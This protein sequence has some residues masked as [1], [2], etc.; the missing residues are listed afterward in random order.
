MDARGAPARGARRQGRRDRPLQAG[1]RGDAQGRRHPR[2]RCVAPTR[3]AASRRGRRAA[4]ARA[5]RHRGQPRQGAPAR[6]ARGRVPRGSCTTTTAP[7][8]PPRRRTRSTR[9]TSTRS[10]VLGDIAFEGAALRR[11]RASTSSRCS[12]APSCST[13]PTP[14]ACCRGFIEAVG[15][16]C[17]RRVSTPPARHDPSA[18]ALRRGVHPRM[19][20]A[21]DELRSSR[22]TTSTC[23][24]ASRACSFEF[25]DPKMAEAAY[26]RAA[27]R[28][29]R[30]PSSRRARQAALSSRRER[31]TRRE[32]SRPPS[33]TC[34]DAADL[35]P[36]SPLALD[37][38]AKVYEK[39]GQVG[40]VVRVKR[41]RL[42]LAMPS[43]RFDL[44]LEIGDIEFQ[45]LERPAR[46]RRRRSRRR[47]RSGRT[48][49]SS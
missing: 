1:A 39:E 40:G 9:R 15:K 16:R 33:P 5:R 19:I 26:A 32:T 45:K 30:T 12:A 37:A 14:S 2:S 31:A 25:G 47:S 42:E 7:R 44:L 20:T 3:S 4:R 43:E 24:R 6:G 46:R 41:Q 38:L 36:T 49:A 35:D 27:R 17:R 8:S 48:T 10:T 22:R 29:G 18:A 28:R 21:V 11:G 34:V 13:R 23:S